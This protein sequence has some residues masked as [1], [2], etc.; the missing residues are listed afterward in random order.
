MRAISP[1]TVDT[2][3][4]RTWDEGAGV[5]LGQARITKTFSGALVGTGLVE[6]LSV[7]NAKGPLSYVALERVTGTLDGHEGTFCFKHAGDIT[8]AGATLD[9]TIVPGTGTGAL[10]SITG[11]ATVDIDAAGK[12]TLLLDYEL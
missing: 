1:F 3:E 5:P 10:A 8:A 7:A 9:L 11:R 6:M 4:A 2:F 12:H